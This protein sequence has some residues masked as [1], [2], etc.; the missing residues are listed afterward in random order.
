MGIPNLIADIYVY[1][2]IMELL[3]LLLNIYRVEKS[4]IFYIAHSTIVK[5]PL[6]IN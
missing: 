4:F 1:T 3:L 6:P 5:A 2:V